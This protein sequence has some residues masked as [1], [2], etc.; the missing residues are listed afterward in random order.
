MLNPQHS[1]FTLIQ[2]AAKSLQ[3][4]ETCVNVLLTYNSEAM[5]SLLA[6]YQHIESLPFSLQAMEQLSGQI[7]YFL[8]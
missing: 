5:E 1:T 4:F 7:G 3:T 6:L 8:A 2:N